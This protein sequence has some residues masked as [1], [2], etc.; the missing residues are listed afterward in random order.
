M[1]Q[2]NVDKV[3]RAYEAL[4]RHDVQAMDAFAAEYAAPHFEF[5]SVLTGQTYHGA[6]GLID[7]AADLWE[8]LDALSAPEELIDAG[9]HVV[10]V[11]R[12]SGR[13]T[14]SGAV[15]SQQIA[16]VWTFDGNQVV[17]GKSFTSRAE[18]LEAAGLRR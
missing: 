9:T 16:V 2:E 11:L 6:Q 13:G 5:E 1:S 12:V 10:V 4:A 8:T 7:Q 3:R 15:V 18:A 14:L 17:R